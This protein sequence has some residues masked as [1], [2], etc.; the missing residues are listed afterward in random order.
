[1]YLESITATNFRNL[2]SLTLEF[3]HGVN[4]FYGDN[5]SGKTNL[6]EAIFVLFLGRSHRAALE[7]VMIHRE[8]DFYRI[9]GTVHSDETTHSVAVACQRV[10]RKKA[11][12][13]KVAVRLAELY[14]K[15]AVVAVGPEDSEILSGPPSMRRNFI[16][17][18]LS[19]YSEKYLSSLISYQ[20]ALGQK[21]AALKRQID[22]APFNDLMIQHG[23]A[24]IMDRRGYLDRLQERAVDYYRQISGGGSFDL[25]YQPS[26]KINDGVCDA[27]TIAATFRQTLS[28]FSER[29]QIME[30]SL[31]GPHRD[32]ISFSINALPART[33]GS[34][35]EWRTAAIALKLALYHLIRE[36]RGI[37]PILL[38]DEIFA[39][40]DHK[41]ARA[42]IGA[43]TEYKQLF[44]TTAVEPPDFLKENSRNYRIVDGEIAEIH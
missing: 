36:R 8:S 27:D 14:N 17:I 32:D 20:K 43:F 7:A 18:Y 16:D 39:E 21:N 2:V 19:Q 34:Q 9:E 38:L 25:Q 28:D 12:I 33:H 41:R 26:V 3:S 4:V 1:M 11:T 10:G 23:A 6:L 40:L 15:F 37:Y 29:E 22:P 42:L 30:S 5:G 44:L 31:I 13:D 35:G 24:I